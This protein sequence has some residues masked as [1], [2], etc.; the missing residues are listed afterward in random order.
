M[1]HVHGDDDKRDL[2]KVN[3]EAIEEMLKESRIQ[4]Y[5]DKDFTKVTIPGDGHCMVQAVIAALNQTYQTEYIKA[6]VMMMMK[7]TL[8]KEIE[9]C[10]DYINNDEIDPIEEMEDYIRLAKYNA[11]FTDMIFP[12]LSR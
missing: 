3:K 4:T 1:S 7:E 5:P 11:N 6:E 10:Q 8:F 2:V 12:I 9:Y